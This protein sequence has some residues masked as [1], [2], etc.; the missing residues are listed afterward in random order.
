MDFPG[1]QCGPLVY[2][3]YMCFIIKFII[4]M[5]FSLGSAHESLGEWDFHIK[6]FASNKSGKFIYFILACVQVYF[7]RKFYLQIS[8]KS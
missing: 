5:E 1:P 4:Y 6:N 3:E 7:L 2:M 8:D